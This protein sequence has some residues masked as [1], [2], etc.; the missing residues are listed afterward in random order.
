MAGESGDQHCVTILIIQIDICAHPSGAESG[1]RHAPSLSETDNGLDIRFQSSIVCHSPRTSL[2][3]SNSATLE[4]IADPL[5]IRNMRRKIEL[6]RLF[7]RFLQLL[8]CIGRIREGRAAFR[9]CGV[10]GR[11]SCR[12]MRGRARA[13]KLKERDRHQ[14]GGQGCSPSQTLS[15]WSVCKLGSQTLPIRWAVVRFL[16]AERSEAAARPPREQV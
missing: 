4:F 5:Q 3:S 12:E 9:H 10:I 1:G 16:H 13:K 7:E 15:D 8:N 2:D 6:T 14:K 11:Y